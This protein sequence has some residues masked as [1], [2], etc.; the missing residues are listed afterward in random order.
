MAIIL[1]EAPRFLILKAALQKCPYKSFKVARQLYWN[2][3]SAWVF[4]FNLLH[5]FK[6]P[7]SKNTS[8][9]LLLLYNSIRNTLAKKTNFLG[10][11]TRKG[12]IT[13]FCRRYL[14]VCWHLWRQLSSLI[15]RATY[16]VVTLL[17]WSR[18]LHCFVNRKLYT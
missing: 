12:V 2:H 9:R 18:I 8:E 11:E 13:K 16:Y 6:T 5:I 17:I 15:Q 4:S 3:H 10:A 14:K 1:L 7:F